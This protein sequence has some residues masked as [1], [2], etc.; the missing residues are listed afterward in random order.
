MAEWN[1]LCTSGFME[2]LSGSKPREN[3]KEKQ[4][5]G[6]LERVSLYTYFKGLSSYP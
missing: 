2:A 5:K 3:R 4:H 6:D 1:S